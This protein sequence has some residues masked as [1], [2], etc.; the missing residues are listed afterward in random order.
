M[1]P[2][3]K[4]TI[5]A[6]SFDDRAGLPKKTARAGIAYIFYHLKLLQ[7]RLN[8]YR[9]TMHLSNTFFFL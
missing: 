6:K 8:I 1:H 4:K 7:Y 2:N 9:I 5:H 3:I